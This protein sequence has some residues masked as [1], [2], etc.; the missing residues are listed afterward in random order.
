MQ[1]ESE[2][3][4]ALCRRPVTGTDGFSLSAKLCDQCRSMI[5]AIKPAEAKPAPNTVPA[6]DTVIAPGQVLAQQ[7]SEQRPVWPESPAVSEP[8]VA[9]QP[10]PPQPYSAQP[11]NSYH[12]PPN[13]E[14][15]Q[16]PASSGYGA[17]SQQPV[18]DQWQSDQWGNA[19]EWPMMVSAEPKKSRGK[20]LLLLVVLLIVVGGGAAAYLKRDAI[21]NMLGMGRSQNPTPPRTGQQDPGRP[22]TSGGESSGAT[23]SSAQTSSNVRTTVNS[24]ASQPQP[25]QTQAGSGSP[26]G[27][28]GATQGSANASATT[29]TQGGVTPLP[30]QKLYALQVASFPNESGA[31]QY[32]EK[33]VRAGV[34]VYVVSADIPRRGRWYRVRAGKFATPDEAR[35]YAADWQQRARAAGISI[36]LVT[37]DY[38]QP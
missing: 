19:G 26:Q 10:K 11:S 32:S 4:C 5:D 16:P 7:T 35:K 9:S 2:S 23:G 24:N 29:P 13:K 22:A 30:G 34:P 17:N 37:C 33:L 20:I 15:A 3:F 18:Q 12:Q 25:S 14:F 21:K 28:P 1:P 27:T 6:G 31:K 38:T 36:Q 8:A